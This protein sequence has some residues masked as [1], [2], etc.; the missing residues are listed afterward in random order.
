MIANIDLSIPYLT[1]HVAVTTSFTQPF[2]SV[3]E[4]SSLQVCTQLSGETAIPVTV[5]LSIEEGRALPNA[6]FIVSDQSFNFPAGSMES[7]VT[8]S[9]MSDAILE[10]DEEFTLVLQPTSTVLTVDDII[11]ATIIDQNGNYG[12]CEC[13]SHYTM[14]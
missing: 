5:P 7:C 4:G 11:T 2:D 12:R 13:T 6:D 1:I 8:I 10:E 3:A 9:A 14:S